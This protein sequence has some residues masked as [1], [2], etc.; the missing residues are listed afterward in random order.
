M[1][2][3]PKKLTSCVLF[4]GAQV[5]CESESILTESAS[6]AFGEK[7][8]GVNPASPIFPS[9]M[10][11]DQLSA[12][13]AANGVSGLGKQ[14]DT[15]TNAGLTENTMA[16]AVPG[17]AGL[18]RAPSHNSFGPRGARLRPLSVGQVLSPPQ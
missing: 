6:G 15:S 12:L 4:A 11:S 5:S 1:L 17:H 2:V 18:R 13:N 3:K 9:T 14:R 10:G 7:K 8:Q 16:K